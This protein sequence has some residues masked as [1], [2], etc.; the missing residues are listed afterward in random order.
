MLRWHGLPLAFL[1]LLAPGLFGD[2]LQLVKTLTVP[3]DAAA[4]SA[5]VSPKGNFVAAACRDGRVR[6]WSF[7]SGELRQ[8]FD[9]KDQ[10]ISGVWFSSDGTLLAAG[11]DRGAVR[12]WSL[13]SGKLKD[14]L[15]VGARVETLTISPDLSLLAVAPAGVPAQLWDLDVGRVLTALP[16]KFAGSAAVSFSPDGK[17]LASADQDTVIRIYEAQTGALRA[18]SED[19]LLETFAIAFSADS[20]YLYAGGADKTISAIDVLS[21]KVARTFPKQSFVVGALQVSRDGKS[22]AAVY[23][24]EKGFSNPAPVLVWDVA[25]QS[26]RTTVQPGVA[27]NGGGFLPDGRLLLTSSAEGKLQVWSVR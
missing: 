26:V 8:A 25:S 20:R 19:F 15:S 21:G 12:I 27:P 17:W 7:P 18:S 23:F 2:S 9:L 4:Q 6:L 1:L 3:S 5:A 11:G 22:L 13:P 10:R 14:E 24:D 16:P